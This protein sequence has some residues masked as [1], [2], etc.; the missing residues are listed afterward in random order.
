VINGF[1]GTKALRSIQSQAEAAIED[2]TFEETNLAYSM[3]EGNKWLAD[4]TAGSKYK[5]GS[6]YTP[7]TD[8]VAAATE[9]IKLIEPDT[10]VKM[11]PTT[12]RFTYWKTKG[13]E[14]TEAK[15]VQT[16]EAT[17]MNN[18]K[19]VQQM[20]VNSWS[21]FRGVE[22]NDFVKNIQ[23]TYKQQVET[24][25]AAIK[26]YKL[27]KLTASKGQKI[28]LDE[29]I[30]YLKTQRTHF[31]DVDVN[32]A[33]AILGSRVGLEFQ[34]Y[35][36]EYLNQT[37][38]A[39]SYSKIKDG[40]FET[41]QGALAVH[42]ENR[43]DARAKA[44]RKAAKIKEDL[45]RQAEGLKYLYKTNDELNDPQEAA[46]RAA[47]VYGIQGGYELLNYGIPNHFHTSIPFL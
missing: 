25:D 39:F 16:L 27:S 19:V 24:Y 11:D 29:S 45:D 21:K 13:E 8:M 43:A 28:Q 4:G 3:R 47:A 46:T 23:D 33:K 6:T 20:K 30:A 32:S 5:G 42:K 15:I 40:G 18:P 36:Q 1:I 7:Y 31:T 44:L 26:K 9:A 38:E 34:I 35:K 14:I 41:N 37:A 10:Y 17:I 2:G 22:D 12:N